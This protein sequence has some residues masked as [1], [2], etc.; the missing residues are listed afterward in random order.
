[1][2]ANYDAHAEIEAF[3]AAARSA[4]TRNDIDAMLSMMT[5]DVVLLGAMGEAVIGRE[6]VRKMYSAL[7]RWV[8][9]ESLGSSGDRSVQIVGTF[10]LVSGTQSALVMGAYGSDSPMK[11]MGPCVH[12][13]RREG[14]QW[15]LA[16]TLILMVREKPSLATVA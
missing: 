1:M 11:V 3:F 5:D 4:R 7:P 12:V 8:S 6:A 13:L 15:K 9:V 16:R 2:S 14:G 10:A